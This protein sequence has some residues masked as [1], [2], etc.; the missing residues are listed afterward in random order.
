MEG[1]RTG[2]RGRRTPGSVSG[3]SRGWGRPRLWPERG[4]AAPNPATHRTGAPLPYDCALRRLCDGRARFAGRGCRQAVKGNPATCHPRSRSNRTF[5]P[6]AWVRLPVGKRPP[7]PHFPDLAELLISPRHVWLPGDQPSPLI[8]PDTARRHLLLIPHAQR[9]TKSGR[10]G[11]S[12]RQW[13]TGDR[14][15]VNPR[16]DAPPI[17]TAPAGR[18]PPL[19]P[20]L[21]I[22]GFS[23]DFS[24][25]RVWAEPSRR[26][27]TA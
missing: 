14:G 1:R 26:R 8:R 25:E 10:P 27:H 11:A 21:P 7:E 19:N 13:A 24:L 2:W 18:E 20:S 23:R 5:P 17:K 16:P 9:R 3:D 12:V 6:G 22:T 4:V 15:E